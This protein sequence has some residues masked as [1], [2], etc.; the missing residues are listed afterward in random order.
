M[1]TLPGFDTGAVSVQDAGAQLAAPSAGRRSP[2]CACSTP[3]RRP[4]ARRCTSRSARPDSPS[5]WRVDDDA[6]AAAARV[7]E[8]L[9]R[10]GLQATLV[11]A[12]LRRGRNRWRRRPFDRVLVDAP[13]SA[14]GVIRRHPDIKLLRRASDIAGFAATQRQILATAFELLKAGG[15]LIYCTCSVLPAENEKVVAAFLDAEPRARVAGWPETVVKPPGLLERPSAGSCCPV[16]TPAPMASTMLACTED[17]MR[18]AN[19]FAPSQPADACCSRPCWPSARR[20]FARRC[21]RRRARGALGL[22]E[23]RTGRV[24]AVRARRV[25]GQR[26]HPRRAQGRPDAH[27]RA[28]RGGVARAALLDGRDVFEYTLKR[29]LMY[30]A[31]SDRYVTR[32][33]DARQHRRSTVTP[34]SKKR[35]R[36]SAP[37]TPGRSWCQPQLSPNREYRVEPARRRAPRAACPTRCAC[38]CSGPT[39]G[40]A[41]ASGSHGPCSAEAARYP[42][43]HRTVGAGERR[44]AAAARALGAE[45]GPVQQAAGVDPADQRDRGDHGQRAAGAQDRR[46]GARVPRAGARL[47]PDG[48]HGGDLRLAGDRAADHRLSIQPRVP[49]PRHRQLVQGRDQA[50]PRPTRSSCRRRRWTCACASTRAA[51]SCS[52]TSSP[53][54]RPPTGPLATDTQRVESG[55]LEVVV[56]G[57]LGQ[58]LAAS[59]AGPTSTSLPRS[60]RR[61]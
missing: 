36:R 11:T 3:A 43:T 6:R 55:A 17:R 54:A 47:A 13:C 14:T 20:R 40:T 32:D 34:R 4:A 27:L 1:Q 57:T 37:W 12:D 44:P 45:L 31:V 41:K 10:A 52:P 25:P 49:E 5:W 58:V 61:R 39:T 29:E 8:N 26:R 42:R 33:V 59:S 7:R 38:C 53:T 19:A 22:R 28:R 51:P 30:H 16:A 46:A 24:P 56:Y 18:A 9:E 23:H 15:R 50:G 2:A 35:S 48:A 21:A 60:R